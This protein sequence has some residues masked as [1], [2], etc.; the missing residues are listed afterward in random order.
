MATGVSIM[1]KSN[2]NSKLVVDYRLKQ[3]DIDFYNENG[4]LVLEDLYSEKF[5]K[6]FL[7]AIRRHAN[8]DFAAII[9]P[10]R[11]EEM[12]KADERPK[13]DLTLQEIKETSTLKLQLYTTILIEMQG[14]HFYSTKM[15]KKDILSH[16]QE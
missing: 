2:D 13:S 1:R 9:N 11:Y 7:S 14:W 3:K 8:N 5:T 10:D 6:M 12:L 16:Q 15:E 4:Y